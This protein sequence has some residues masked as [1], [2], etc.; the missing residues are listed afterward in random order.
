MPKSKEAI[1]PRRLSRMKAAAYLDC[2]YAYLI[3]LEKDNVPE[4]V[5][6]TSWQQQGVLRRR[7]TERAM[8]CRRIVEVESGLI[9]NRDWEDE[10]G[11]THNQ[12]HNHQM[13][14]KEF[15]HA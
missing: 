8:R 13:T 14:R 15:R 5:A 4:A 10:P 2:S 9:L 6:D 11:V 12:E 7:A 1:Q 3:Q